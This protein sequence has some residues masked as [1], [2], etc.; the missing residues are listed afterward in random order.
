MNIKFILLIFL[1]LNQVACDIIEPEFDNSIDQN[2]IKFLVKN[3]SQ[4]SN[5]EIKIINDSNAP[6]TISYYKTQNCNFFLYE[7]EE[8]ANGNWIKLE[9][10]SNSEKWVDPTNENPDSIFSVCQEYKNPV[11]INPGKKYLV[12]IHKTNTKG[13][14]RL[15]IY[16]LKGYTYYP[17]M[18][19][20]KVQ[21]PYLVMF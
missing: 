5:G 11:V 6:I 13:A 9:Y 19:K 20:E 2:G 17:E 8:F 4:F 18:E 10:D 1:I 3:A 14:F 7:I 21:I 15:T 16:Y 12:K